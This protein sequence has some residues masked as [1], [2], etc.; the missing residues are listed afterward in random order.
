MINFLKKFFKNSTALKKN[1]RIAREK[2]YQ[3]IDIIILSYFKLRG[4]PMIKIHYARI[5]NFGDLLNVDILNYFRFK[6]VYVSDSYKSQVALT[7]SILQHFDRNFQGYVLGAGFIDSR[8]KRLKNN[9]Q[10]KIIRGPKSAKQC[11]MK[12]TDR[13]LYGDPGIL[14][15]QIFKNAELQKTY[16][17]GLVPHYVDYDFCKDQ[18][19]DISNVLIINVRQSPK[20][21]AEEIQQCK[22]IASSSLHGL[23]FADSFRIPNIHLKLGN[24]LNG[25]LHKFEDYYLGMDSSAEV[26]YYDSVL[27]IESIISKCKLRFDSDYLQNKQS[28][29]EKVL[30]T[31]FQ[32]I[33][34]HD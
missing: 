11:G 16:R 7:G 25:G 4:Y 34:S 30:K 3:F 6:A 15:S 29:M 22:N 10:V 17:L 28:A 32:E 19:G 21:V 20:K 2:Y 24:K 9:W 18:F 8:F 5:K 33:A 23:I 26:L 12:D 13:L 27:T 14:A 31:T 1:A